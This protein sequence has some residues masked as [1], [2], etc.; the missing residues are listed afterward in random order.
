MQD[1]KSQENYTSRKE[2]LIRL[3]KK[4]NLKRGHLLKLSRNY[5]N[6]RLLILVIETV[7]FF[8]FFFTVSNLSALI[9][10]ATFLVVFSLIAHFHNKLDNGIKKLE[11]WVKIKTINLARM[12]LDWKGIPPVSYSADD[13][14]IGPNEADLNL[15]GDESL[16][17][18][19]NACTS[20]QAKS[21]LRKWLN[22][23]EPS[24]KE[25]T[26]RQ[27]LIRELIP[28]SRFRD[29]LTLYSTFSSRPD[30]DGKT[31]F[32][33][34]NKKDVL[35]NS[36]KVI[37]GFMIILAPV[38]ILLFI[39]FLQNILPAYWGITTLTY[40]ALLHFG[41]KEKGKQL[42][43]AEYISDELEK[44]S[45]VFRFLEEYN[46]IAGSGL[47]K[48]CEPFK[49]N[50]EQP[51][52]LINK[53]KNAIGFLRIRK[54]NPFVWNMI[55]AAFPIDFYFRLRLD[56][57]IQLVSGKFNIWLE[58]W[59]RL[60]ALSSLATFAFLNPEYTF[61]EIIE[62]ENN[63][64]IFSGRKLG[65]PLIK[66][67][68]KI[69]NDFTFNPEGEIAIITGSNMSGKSTFIR[70]LGINLSLAYAGSVV[71][72]EE[73]KISLLR[74]FTCIR[75]SD[76]VIDG[77][78]YF[79]AEVKR[80]KAL[81]DEIEK[82]EYP[83]F[84]LIDEIFRGTNNIERLKGSSSYIKKLAGTNSVGAIA[85]HDLELIKLSEEILKVKN[86]HF[87]EE[88]KAGRM[89]FDYKLNN[90]PS[91]TTNALKIMKL[92]GLPIE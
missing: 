1:L 83:V 21:L 74:L 6:Y 76:S 46:F 52:V 68:N 80:L 55:R 19:I 30:F 82:S 72:A 57:L 60:E 3:I 54:G 48:L 66:K 43:E 28:L 81:L 91:P 32:G 29:K 15:T 18:L 61:P 51:S 14:K 10:L 22:V 23:K 70:T 34:L 64:P 49:A 79:Y 41:N 50:K 37:F 78:S 85:T 42:E 67:E 88:I 36:F 25:I 8:F 35:T 38:N 27:S 63:H 5:S 44:I 86:Y 4:L 12:S 77:I 69:C 56:K 90:G 89:I 58:S 2:Y 53:I 7:I 16:H 17:Q 87:K 31:L 59:Y 9:S 39:L 26:D 71:N 20:Q 40:I 75:V 24:I 73:L 92:E 65:H 45:S 13:G 33:L 62:S 47:F 84:F 11:L